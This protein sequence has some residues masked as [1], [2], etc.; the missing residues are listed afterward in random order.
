[1]ICKHGI[2]SNDKPC[3]RCK[4]SMLHKQKVFSL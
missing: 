3:K 4:A 1:M 2:E